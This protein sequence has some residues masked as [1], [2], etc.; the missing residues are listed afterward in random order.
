[1]MN[2]V[3][4]IICH[5][6]DG[7]RCGVGHQI[8]ACSV[9]SLCVSR[10]QPWESYTATRKTQCRWRVTGFARLQNDGLENDGVEQEQTYMLYPMKNFNVYDM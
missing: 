1:M 3:V 10:R 6:G 5:I 9:S 7:A 4:Y 2:K 8:D